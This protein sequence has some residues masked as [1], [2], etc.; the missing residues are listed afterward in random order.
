MIIPSRDNSAINYTQG[1]LD[2]RFSV[3]IY[4][5]CEEWGS[6]N[7]RKEELRCTTQLLDNFLDMAFVCRIKYS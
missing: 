1:Y 5:I 7:Y 2:S 4:T 6:E 3:V